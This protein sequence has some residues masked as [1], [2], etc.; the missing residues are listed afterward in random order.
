MKKSQLWMVLVVVMAFAPVM[1]GCGDWINRVTGAEEVGSGDTQATLSGNY[2]V[3]KPFIEGGLVWGL[4]GDG[5]SYPTMW[6]GSRVVLECEGN[7]QSQPFSA[8]V[9]F[10]APVSGQWCKMK[11]VPTTNVNYFF[12]PSRIDFIDD[13]ADVEGDGFRR[14]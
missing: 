10:S 12:A 9:T 14:R 4:D 3:V 6:S 13:W 2:L 1:S 7:T 11:F 5:D 8:E